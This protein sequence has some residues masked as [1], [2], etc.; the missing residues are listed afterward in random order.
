M[1]TESFSDYLDRH[2]AYQAVLRLRKHFSGP[3]GGGTMPQRVQNALDDLNTVQDRLRDAI[4]DE[5]S[6]YRFEQLTK[7]QNSVDKGG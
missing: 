3:Y 4:H 7:S 1:L 2:P 5:F 6:D